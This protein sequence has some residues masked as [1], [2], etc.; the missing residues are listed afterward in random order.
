MSDKYNK[1]NEKEKSL[2]DAARKII[3]QQDDTKVWGLPEH[4]HMLR[5]ILRHILGDELI[6]KEESDA[7]IELFLIKGAGGNSSQ[8]RQ[9]LEELGELPKGAAKRTRGYE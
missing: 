5:N 1:L 8:F 2:V 7:M 4:A 6:G 3:A 9:W